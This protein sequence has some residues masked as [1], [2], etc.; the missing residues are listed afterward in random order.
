MIMITLSIIQITELMIKVSISKIFFLS[1]PANMLLYS[2]TG[3]IIY[4]MIKALLTKK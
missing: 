4:K 2:I 1:V 3:L